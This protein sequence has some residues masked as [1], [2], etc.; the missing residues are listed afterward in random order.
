MPFDKQNEFL[1]RMLKLRQI[2]EKVKIVRK[3]LLENEI[4]ELFG[5]KK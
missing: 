4:H 5:G 3:S 2:N 1:V